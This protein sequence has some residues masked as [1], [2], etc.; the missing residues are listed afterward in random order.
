MMRIAAP[1]VTRFFGSSPAATEPI[2]RRTTGESGDAPLTLSAAIAY[3][4]IAELASGG[5]SLAAVMSLASTWPRASSNGVSRESSTVK[6]SRMRSHASS[7][8]SIDSW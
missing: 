4:S 2:T 1:G 7:T 5:M 8:L 6:T 3:P